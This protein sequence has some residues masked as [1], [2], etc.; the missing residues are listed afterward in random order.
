MRSNPGAPIGTPLANVGA[1]GTKKERALT[2]RARCASEEMGDGAP[3]WRGGNAGYSADS[4]RSGR[5]RMSSGRATATTGLGA[6]A[7]TLIRRSPATV[8]IEYASLAS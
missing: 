8:M 4:Q 1:R 6:L 2:W 7:I 3:A 5:S